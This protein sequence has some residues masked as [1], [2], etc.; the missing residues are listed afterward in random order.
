MGFFQP[1]SV[2][3]AVWPPLT[4]PNVSP[5]WSSYQTLDRTQW[6]PPKELEAA[7]LDQV[8]CLLQHSFENVPYYRK[9][10]GPFSKDP[11]RDIGAFRRLPLLTREDFR[12]NLAHMT[13]AKLPPGMAVVEHPSFT[14]GTNGVPIRVM[15]SDQDALWHAAFCMRDW[16]WSHMNPRKV[17]AAIRLVA[18]SAK[19]LPAAMSGVV[20][21]GWTTFSPHVFQNE[22]AYALDI[23]QDPRLQLEWLRR[24]RPS[25]LISYPS[26]LEVLAG[27]AK[28]GNIRVS[29]LEIVQTIGE[30]LT[31]EAKA[32]IE[33]AFQVQV[34]NLYSV[35]E[36]GYVASPC[37]D[38]HGLHVHSENFL[39][40]VLREDDT[41]CGPGETGRIVLTNLHNFV[42]P[43]IRYDIQDY[44]T[45][46]TGPCPCGRGLPLWTRVDGRRHPMLWLPD[47]SRRISTGLILG[48]RQVGG[49]RQFQIVQRRDG[50]ILVRVVP[51]SSWTSGNEAKVV[52]LVRGEIG[53]SDTVVEK[54]SVLERTGG[55]KLKIV[56]VEEP[57]A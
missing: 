43:F 37:P 50:S 45:L 27:L 48:V 31:D 18:M 22:R 26:N 10:L 24:L 4:D 20:A 47:G 35:T 5:I 57:D 6:L 55:G 28:D 38:G 3:G 42:N 41:P 36:G 54:L 13:A 51:D 32:L 9:V 30:P 11:V 34:K 7:Q 1:R 49:L 53:R 16:E 40:E 19:D 25:Y 8:R 29:N 52:D 14:S 2:P 33:G 23:R 39:A 17:L 46:A 56:V 44:A 15:K 12:D 21:Q